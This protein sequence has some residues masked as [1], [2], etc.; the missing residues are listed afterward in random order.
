MPVK[1]ISFAFVFLSFALYINSILC[2]FVFDDTSAIL[3]NKDVF[4]ESKITDLL[5]NDYWGTSMS[6][7]R[8]ATMVLVKSVL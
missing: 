3:K 7:V 5:W 8:Y 1:Y 2:G 6:D 4:G